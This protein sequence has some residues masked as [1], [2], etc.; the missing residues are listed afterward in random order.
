MDGAYPVVGG[1]R[2]CGGLYFVQFNT[3]GCGIRAAKRTCGRGRARGGDCGCA[4]LCDCD[5]DGGGLQQTARGGA[6]FGAF[7]RIRFARRVGWVVLSFLHQQKNLVAPAD[8]GR[9]GFGGCGRVLTNLFGRARFAGNG[10]A[11]GRLRECRR[12]CVCA[13][14]R[15]V[16]VEN[17][18]KKESE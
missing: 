18:T 1:V 5:G 12:A 15:M 7:F 17:R 8:G 4:E 3:N 13:I 11:C 2:V 9:G 10:Y 16:G 6:D 14:H